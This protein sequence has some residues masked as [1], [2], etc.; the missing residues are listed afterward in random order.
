V[1]TVLTAVPSAL[2][3]LI[4]ALRLRLGDPSFLARHRVRPEDFTRRRKL[5]FLFVMLFILQK[6]VRSV[7]R[8]L[9]DFLE[10]VADKMDL[11]GATLGALTHARAKLKHT[12]FI[13]LS[14]ECVLPAIYA[15]PARPPK[16]WR[17]HRLL[18]MDSSILR[19]PNN[20]EL[21]QAFTPVDVLC[22]F[23]PTGVGMAQA[24][25]SVLYDLLNRA[26]LDARLEPSALGEVELAIQQLSQA[27]P[28]DVVLS[29][30]GY[31]G[32]QYLAAHRQLGVHF[33]VRCS[34]GSFA[35]AQELF[36]LNQAAVSRVATLRA[37]LA[38]RARM[39]REG[40]PLELTV[41]LVSVRLSTGELEVL[42]TSL[43]DETLYPTEEFLA[44]YGWR[45]NQETFYLMLKSRLDL[46]N[47]SGET[48]DAVR[49][50]F[51][52]AMLL[53]NLESILTQ[54][55]QQALAAR[56]VDN[57]RQHPQQVNR[58]NSYH[59]LKSRLLALLESSRA[60]EETLL[61]LQ[62]MFMA[63]PVSVRS[64]AAKR[65]KPSP[66]RAYH[67]QKRVKKTVF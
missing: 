49:Q 40:W 14:Q 42:V 28:G 15:N 65:N 55:A 39:Q 10:Q 67:Y 5:P 3:S 7:Q 44:V 19:L 45:W 33:V 32:Y 6:T 64:R 50:D 9:H 36:G 18:G 62:K 26:G 2:V 59:A 8:H 53:C 37:P 63:T 17:G 34:R 54:P 46:E 4:L 13:E 60:P 57:P 29:D 52:A 22:Q 43:L 56:G 51:Y 58:A 21:R 35:G 1:R 12:A 66:D 11:E 20:P 27:R 61:E 31:A 25:I 48:A 38:E 23:G 47:F 41:R 24:R 30:R 16:L